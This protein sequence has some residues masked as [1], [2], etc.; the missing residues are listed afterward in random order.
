MDKSTRIE[1]LWER[2]LQSPNGIIIELSSPSAAKRLRF[3]LYFFRRDQRQRSKDIYPKY[4]PG[5][6]V[7]IYDNLEVKVIA[8]R[9][10]INKTPTTDLEFQIVERAPRPQTQTEPKAE[11]IPEPPPPTDLSA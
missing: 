6:G 9:L 1:D 8:N 7:S 2:A 5:Y 3:Q 10:E 4:D 11:P